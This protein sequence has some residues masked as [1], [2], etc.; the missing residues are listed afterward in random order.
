MRWYILATSRYESYTDDELA[1]LAKSDK[2]A[3]DALLNRYLDSLHYAAGSYAVGR[4][5]YI[6][7]DDYRSEGV[8]GL[9]NAVKHFDPNGDASFATFAR[10][11]SSNRMINAYKKSKKVMNFETNFDGKA[12]DSVADRSGDI[13][14]REL[15]SAVADVVDNELSKL[16]ANVFLSYLS[17]MTYKEIAACLDISEKSVDNA[18]GRVRRK[19]RD[20]I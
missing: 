6:D 10:V 20:K 16:E 5:G 19:L 14:L 3:F 17:G 2:N 12:V 1:V 13:S 15:G 8:L 4:K 7:A 11:C 9:M 18:L